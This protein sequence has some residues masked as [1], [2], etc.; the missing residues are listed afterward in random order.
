[1][2]RRNRRHPFGVGWMRMGPTPHPGIVIAASMPAIEDTK[3]I[4]HKKTMSNQSPAFTYEFVEHGSDS[5]ARYAGAVRIG[6][7]PALFRRPALI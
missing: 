1:M 3:T 7:S 4:T 5:N 6:K 2:S